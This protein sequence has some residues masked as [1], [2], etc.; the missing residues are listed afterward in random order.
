[1]LGAG[2]IGY[3]ILGPIP[4]PTLI[5]LMLQKRKIYNLPQILALLEI[6]YTLESSD[7]F[8][9]LDSNGT[10]LLNE[11]QSSTANSSSTSSKA[12]SIFQQIEEDTIFPTVNITTVGVAQ[13]VGNT[14]LV[15]GQAFDVGS[16]IKD[17]GVR[18]DD[19]RFEPANP[20]DE[21]GWLFWSASVPV[22]GLK[23]GD[24][25]VVARA[26]DN[27]NNTKREAVGFS[28]Q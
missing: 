16:D 28:V 12:T 3:G 20:D 13:P 18:V 5:L 10:T 9:S 7:Q 23:A 15:T 11:K 6:Q 19:G 1:M 26:T 27:A 8:P 2:H 25:E 17:V 24:H 22:E 4:I 14:V 21:K